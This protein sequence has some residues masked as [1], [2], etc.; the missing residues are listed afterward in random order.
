MFTSASSSSVYSFIYSSISLI[1]L[2][3][4]LAFSIFYLAI[5]SSLGKV[6][7]QASTEN[8]MN[9]LPTSSFLLILSQKV[10]YYISYF[11][12]YFTS[13]SYS[14]SYYYCCSEL[15]L[16]SFYSVVYYVFYY[17][18]Y[19]LLVLFSVLASLDAN[20]DLILSIFILFRSILLTLSEKD[21][22]ALFNI[23]W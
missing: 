6:F 7:L 10:S 12:S 3:Y 9:L 15:L 23:S 18:Y 8:F 4:S 22:L 2:A 14:P 21:V 11:Y 19:V 17:D 1:F 16:F 13:P 5:K 20:L